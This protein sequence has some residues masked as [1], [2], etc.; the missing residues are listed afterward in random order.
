LAHLA[1][2]LIAPQKGRPPGRP[3][4]HHRGCKRSVWDEFG[5]TVYAKVNYLTLTR[6]LSGSAA[7]IERLQPRC[8]RDRR[9]HLAG[10]GNL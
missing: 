7:K 8:R 10:S 9:T 1:D 3:F 4:S 6:T 2:D 5:I